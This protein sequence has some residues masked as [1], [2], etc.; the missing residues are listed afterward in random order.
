[1]NVS[2]NSKTA[3]KEVVEEYVAQK[4]PDFDKRGKKLVLN[5]RGAEWEVLYELPPEMLGG[6][7]VVV[8]DKRTGK[9]LRS[10]RTQ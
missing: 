9:V 5:D 6:S 10:F 8:V 2:G 7:P 1:M 4:Y 3:V